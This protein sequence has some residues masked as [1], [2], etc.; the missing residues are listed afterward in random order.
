VYIAVQYTIPESV[1][2]L[3]LANGPA[4]AIYIGTVGGTVFAGP[5]IFTTGGISIRTD[6]NAITAFPQMD[7]HTKTGTTV[8][9]VWTGQTGVSEG[10]YINSLA[11]MATAFGATPT[12]IITGP[13]DTLG[14]T[15]VKV[16]KNGRVHVFWV[17][18]V[19]ANL[20]A[21]EYAYSDDGGA[22]FSVPLQ[23]SPFTYTIT[24]WP[25]DYMG[26]GVDS[27]SPGNAYVAYSVANS[28]S[29]RGIY[30]TRLAGAVQ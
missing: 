17:Q 29:S 1:Q 19:S 2:S 9:V 25:G 10:V 12:A 30:V 23:V 3:D 15:V 6:Q 26:A 24:D 20:W 18:N 27:N 7:I 22:T 13:A 4:G 14:H 5:Y 28:G 21:V 16:D 8:Y 11:P